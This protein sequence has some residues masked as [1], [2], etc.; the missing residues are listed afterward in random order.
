MRKD[1]PTGLQSTGAIRGKPVLW[2]DLK[3]NGQTWNHQRAYRQRT[4][5]RIGDEEAV[6]SKQLLIAQ[7]GSARC[8]R[9]RCIAVAIQT[10]AWMPALTELGKVGWAAI[11]SA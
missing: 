1:N 3:T 7:Q 2:A 4:V 8:C 5:G 9:S 10:M 11:S 6:R